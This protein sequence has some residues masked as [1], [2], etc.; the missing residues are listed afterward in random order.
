[1][2]NQKKRNGN[3]M[4]KTTVY[5]PRRLY[6]S[7]KFMA[8]YTRSSLTKLMRVSLTEKIDKLK[9]QK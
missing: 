6:E 2:E 5:L 4:V 7:A 3:E 8:I 1:M 9:G